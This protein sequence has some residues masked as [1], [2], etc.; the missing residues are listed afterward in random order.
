ML[1]QKYWNVD[2]LAVELKG[3]KFAYHV[4]VKDVVKNIHKNFMAKKEMI[5]ALFAMLSH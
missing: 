4:C 1:V 5:I 3:K 2:T